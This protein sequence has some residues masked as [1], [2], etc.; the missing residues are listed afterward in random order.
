MNDERTP[1]MLTIKET[2]KETGIS[3]DSI[4]KLCMQNK[5]VYIRLGAKYLVNYDRFIDYLNGKEKNA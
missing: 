3:Y 2:A 4:R 5:I 1:R